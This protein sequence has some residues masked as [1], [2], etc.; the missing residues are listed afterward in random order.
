MRLAK[1]ALLLVGIFFG[2]PRSLSPLLFAQAESSGTVCVRIDAVRDAPGFW[3][4]I[5]A[6]T[7][8]LSAT[9]ISSA[10]PEYKVGER[11]TFSIPVV[12]GSRL[13]DP[14]VPRLNPQLVHKQAI[15]SLQ[16]SDSC[17]EPGHT[18]WIFTC[19]VPGCG[20]H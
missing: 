8:S 4:G 20:K 1:V 16:T 10:T 11:L 9:V 18:D 5:L 13:A 2:I 6:A 7:Q 12:K 15:L 14:T 17:R 3:S 19:V